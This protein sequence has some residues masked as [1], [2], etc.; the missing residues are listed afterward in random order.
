LNGCQ[1]PTCYFW[2]ETHQLWQRSSYFLCLGLSFLSEKERGGLASSGLPHQTLGLPLMGW[3]AGQMAF[4][5]P[6][7]P[8]GSITVLFQAM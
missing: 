5:S 7:W 4:N 2:P 3:G 8:L 6:R 1:G